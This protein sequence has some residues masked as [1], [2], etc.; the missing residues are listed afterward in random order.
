[1]TRSAKLSAVVPRAGTRTHEQRQQKVGVG[2]PRNAGPP[3]SD[4]DRSLV[5]SK[6]RDG[7]N[8]EELAATLERSRT[9]GARLSRW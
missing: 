3:W 7:T 4:E 9:D 6:F 1:V 2:Q 5:A 8:M